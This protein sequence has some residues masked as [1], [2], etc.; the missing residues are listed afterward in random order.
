[1][2]R[3]GFAVAPKP[4]AGPLPLDTQLSL[5]REK[6]YR[7][8]KELEKRRFQWQTHRK[9]MKEQ[10]QFYLTQISKMNE[11]I[12]SNQPLKA[13]ELGRRLLND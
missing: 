12:L 13:A 4:D 3:S 6:T 5:E 2:T 10:K 8:K 11:L 1:M 7:L 9:Q